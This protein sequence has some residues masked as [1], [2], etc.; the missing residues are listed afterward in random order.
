LSGNRR[1]MSAMGFAGSNPL[2]F[3]KQFEDYGLKGKLAVLPICDI[4]DYDRRQ[5]E[6]ARPEILFARVNR[7]SSV[8]GR[9][10]DLFHE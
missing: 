2:R 7:R 8:I 3:L 9:R 5:V 10:K 1:L 6:A 4:G